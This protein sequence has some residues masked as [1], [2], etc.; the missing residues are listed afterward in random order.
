MVTKICLAGAGSIGRRHL[1]LLMERSDVQ[2]CVAEPNPMCRQAVQEEFPQV[3]MYLSMEEAVRA[4]GCEA[5]II[6]TLRL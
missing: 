4:E 3:P 2:M 5:V 1:R 6:A